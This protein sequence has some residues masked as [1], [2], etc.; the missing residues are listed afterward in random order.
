MLLA[1]VLHLHTPYVLVSVAMPTSKPG[2]AGGTVWRACVC[3]T[4][5]K[6]SRT[7]RS[8]RLT[9]DCV[10]DKPPPHSVAVLFAPHYVSSCTRQPLRCITESFKSSAPPPPDPFPFQTSPQC[11]LCSC[12][13]RTCPLSIFTSPFFCHFFSPV[14]QRFPHIHAWSNTGFPRRGARCGIRTSLLRSFRSSILGCV[15]CGPRPRADRITQRRHCERRLL[16]GHG[17]QCGKRPL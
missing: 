11:S 5:R 16:Q 4:A 10:V 9:H 15:F 3:S 1:Q 7:E 6:P 12:C 17:L 13:G 8:S 14:P 2:E